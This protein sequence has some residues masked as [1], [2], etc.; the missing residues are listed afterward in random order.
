MVAADVAQAY[1]DGRVPTNISYITP[2]YLSQSRDGPA[3]SG[4]LAIYII[5]TVLLICRFTSRIFIVKSFGL[6]DSIAAFSWVCY[7]AFMALCLVLIYEGSGRHIAYIQYVLTL[8]EVEK[9]EVVDYAAHL[10]Y[11]AT[12]YFCRLSGLAFF[13]RICSTHPTFRIAIWACGAFLTAAFIVQFLL[14]LLHCLPV[15]GLWPYAW[16]TTS[17]TYK[18]LNWG[19]VYVTNS[20]LS[21]VNDIFLFSIPIA[22]ISV[23]QLPKGRKIMLTIVMLP[24][25]LVIGISCARLWLCVVGQWRTDGSWYY[26]P[27]LVIE[28]AE[29]GGTLIAL[30]VPSYKPIL[31]RWYDRMKSTVEASHGP[32]SKYGDGMSR[33]K[34][35]VPALWGS[36]VADS[37]LKTSVQSG[38]KTTTGSRGSSDNSLLNPDDNIYVTTDVDMRSIPMARLRTDSEC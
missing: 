5:T 17:R 38:G 20:G 19:V 24:G 15:T 33:R 6:D 27:Q 7:T 13:S 35:S 8:P 16:Q 10:I 18:C 9:T 26:D 31:S 4:I 34:S 14:I 30:S 3:I 2:D 32:N 11:T 28:V 37:K 1:A 21:L 12:L 25:T 36:Q 23:L 29:I 22:M